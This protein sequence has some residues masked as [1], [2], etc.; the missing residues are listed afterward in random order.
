VSS[1][2]AN[3]I[4]SIDEDE[5]IAEQRVDDPVDA[6]VGQAAVEVLG[7]LGGGEVTALVPGLHRR[8]SQ[9]YEQV[10]FTGAGDSAYY[11]AA[12]RG[13]VRRVGARFSVM[14]QIGPKIAA[15][16]ATIG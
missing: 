14:V 9:C 6:V 4:S 15:A 16:I 1:S 13:A 10:G 3:P 8:G 5:V 7:E 2:G 11:S 12:F